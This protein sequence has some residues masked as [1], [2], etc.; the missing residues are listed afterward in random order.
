AP[1][2]KASATPEN[3]DPTR[4]ADLRSFEPPESA[5]MS[6]VAA[7]I[8]RR[9]GEAGTPPAES[10]GLWLAGLPGGEVVAPFDGRVVYAGPFANLGLVLIIRHGDAYHAVLAALGRV[11]VAVGQWVLAGEP[12]GAMPD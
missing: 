3:S 2:G 6:P 5:L 4:P 10:E 7:V 12:V 9:F 8:L 11:D 1:K